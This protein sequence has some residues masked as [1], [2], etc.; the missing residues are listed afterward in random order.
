MA[1][2]HTANALYP[3]E[4]AILNDVRPQCVSRCYS[5]SDAKTTYADVPSI[6]VRKSRDVFNEEAALKNYWNRLLNRDPALFA[7]TEKEDEEGVP[8]AQAL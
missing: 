7:N 3:R 4:A 2:S 1:A 5:Q 6:S 8:F